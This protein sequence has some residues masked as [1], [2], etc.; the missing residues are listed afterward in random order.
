MN[1]AEAMDI[2]AYDGILHLASR[3]R[4]K[5]LECILAVPFDPDLHYPLAYVHLH[6]AML[7]IGRK[8]L[9]HTTN[10][11]DEAYKDL[12][13]YHK[14]L[15]ECE[16]S[17]VGIFPLSVPYRRWW[18]GPHLDFPNRNKITAWFPLRVQEVDG[19]DL[20]CTVGK[21]EGIYG[22][23]KFSVQKATHPVE[24]DMMGEVVFYGE[25]YLIDFHREKTWKYPSAMKVYADK[26]MP[27]LIRSNETL[28]KRIEENLGVA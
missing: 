1:L 2:Y 9:D 12:D 24:E 3:D 13:D 18:D 8:I 22:N 10:K 7:D 21:K 28:R 17:H 11:E 23:S 4:Y 27:Y 14:A 19:D 20:Y 5:N 16:K 6:F 15:E 25:D 26:A